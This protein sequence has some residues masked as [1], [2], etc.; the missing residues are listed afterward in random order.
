MPYD[1]YGTY[2]ASARD[3]EN[4]EMAQRAEIDA[5]LAYISSQKLEQKHIDS[6]LREH[7]MCQKIDYLMYKIQELENRIVEFESR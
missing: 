2:Y 4:A 7:E 6:Q 1:L 5:N 3:A